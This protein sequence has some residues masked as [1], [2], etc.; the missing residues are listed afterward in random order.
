MAWSG[1][2]AFHIRVDNFNRFG[3]SFRDI[4]SRTDKNAS[5]ILYGNLFRSRHGLVFFTPGSVTRPAWLTNRMRRHRMALVKHIEVS[6][7]GEHE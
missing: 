3:L 7:K 2:P 1:L 5:R 6:P 4:K